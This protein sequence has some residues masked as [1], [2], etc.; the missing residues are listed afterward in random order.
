MI[1]IDFT[2]YADTICKDDDGDV[3]VTVRTANFETIVHR[4]PLFRCKVERKKDDEQQ[5]RR[6]HSACFRRAD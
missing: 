4:E 1:A 2:I 6:K 5:H 3:D